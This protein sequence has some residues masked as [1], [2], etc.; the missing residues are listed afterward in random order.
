[1]SEAESRAKK[2]CTLKSNT[3]MKNMEVKKTYAFISNLLS[4]APIN[5]SFCA[6]VLTS[7][8]D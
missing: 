5:P 3:D 8:V 2:S 7:H 4:L 6:S 1:L